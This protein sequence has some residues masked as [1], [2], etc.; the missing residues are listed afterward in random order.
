M[1]AF[2]FY[3]TGFSKILNKNDNLHCLLKLNHSFFPLN[4]K[5]ELS[6]EVSLDFSK[7]LSVLITV[8][9]TSVFHQQPLEGFYL[10]ILRQ[11]TDLQIEF[12]LLPEIRIRQRD[13]I[14]VIRNDT[15]PGQIDRTPHIW[16]QDDSRPEANNECNRHHDSWYPNYSVSFMSRMIPFFYTVLLA[17][18]KAG[19]FFNK[20]LLLSVLIDWRNTS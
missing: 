14:L 16:G 11:W 6:A 8:L 7:Y 1:Q 18:S 5:I 12:W 9:L 17:G 13:L 2:C 4:L 20:H 19:L 15:D 3:E 10:K